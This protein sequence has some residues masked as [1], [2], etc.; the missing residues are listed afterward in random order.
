M[1]KESQTPLEMDD[2]ICVDKMKGLGAGV[3]EEGSR[4]RGLKADQWGKELVPHPS[5]ISS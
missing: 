5:F 1:S 3:Q 2:S 4:E